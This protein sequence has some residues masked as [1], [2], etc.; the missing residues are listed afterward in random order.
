[1][2]R[3]GEVAGRVGGWEGGGGRLSRTRYK[4]RQS[5]KSISLTLHTM[6]EFNAG[7]LPLQPQAPGSHFVLC[8]PPQF[9]LRSL[10]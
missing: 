3:A 6:L 1:M 7:H 4:S 10:A 5:V 8:F 2:M 9:I